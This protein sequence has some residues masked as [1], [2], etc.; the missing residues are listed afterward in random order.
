ME[1]SAEDV[2]SYRMKHESDKEWNLRCAFLLAH[3][4][5]FM[6]SRLRCLSSCYINVEC[7]GCRYPPAL[8]RQLS[9][10]TAEMPKQN[11]QSSAKRGLPQ[12]VKFVPAG[13]EGNKSASETTQLSQ[14]RN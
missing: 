9:E 8:M 1:H 7:Y 5:K 14:W 10:L 6:D 4:D 12:S 11:S 13:Q 2:N 3:R